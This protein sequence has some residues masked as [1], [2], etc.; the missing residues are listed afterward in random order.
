MDLSRNITGLEIPQDAFTEHDLQ[1]LTL[2]CH[3]NWIQ[4]SKLSL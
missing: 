3:L 2:L 1:Y 4:N